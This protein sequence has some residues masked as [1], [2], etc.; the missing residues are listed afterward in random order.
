MGWYNKGTLLAMNPQR[1]AA[2]PPFSFS[3]D[4]IR[5]GLMVASYTFDVEDLLL[6]DSLGVGSFE[7]LVKGVTGYTG[8]GDSRNL[9]SVTMTID[10]ANDRTELDAADLTY[11]QLGNGTNGTFES[12]IVMRVATTETR[13][14]TD[15]IAH[16]AVSATLT[17]GGD[18]TLQ[19]NAAGILHITT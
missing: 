7:F 12:I 8:I 14:T 17:N 16:S 5:V 3:A 10:T 1:A 4:K 6:G 11:S 2:N 15:L 13:T 9:A 18:I 19:W